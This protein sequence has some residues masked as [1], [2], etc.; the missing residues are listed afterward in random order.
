M[1]RKFS[2]VGIVSIALLMAGC[3]NEIESAM[4]DT[5]DKTNDMTKVLKGVTDEASA[6]AAVPKVKAILA[7]I[8]AIDA[9]MDKIDKTK[10]TE[11]D[12]AAML[13]YLE[14]MAKAQTELATEKMRVM[15]FS[16]ELAAAL[17]GM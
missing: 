8:K 4:S 7:D 12:A 15:K 3:K 2:L 5:V 13:K 1:L 6:K 17:S 11:K 9:R 14:P 16:P 10:F